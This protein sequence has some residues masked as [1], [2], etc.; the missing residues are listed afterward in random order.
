[1]KEITNPLRQDFFPKDQWGPEYIVKA[2]DP[3]TRMEGILVID[4]T[5]LG[6]GKGG[7]RMTPDITEEEIFRLARAMTM[8]N[9]LA[10][11]SFG[12]AKS[13]I[14]YN[15]EGADDKKKLVQ[16]FAKAIKMFS[17]EKY[18]AG[19]DVNTGS[20]EMKWFAQAEGSWKSA[21]GKPSRVCI[22]IPGERKKRCGIPHELGSTGYGV[23]QAVITTL[24]M[25]EI[26]IKSASVAIDGFGNVGSFV[27]KYLKNEGAH[28]VAVSDIRGTVYDKKGLDGEELMKTKK[29]GMPVIFYS[30]GVKLKRNAIFRL[31]VD[32]LIPA[33]V[34]DVINERNKNSVKA[35]VI[36]EAANIPMREKIEEE[37]FNRGIFVAPDIVVNAGGVISS[38]AEYSGLDPE[39]M[40]G[41]VKRKITGNVKKIIKESLRRNCNPR[42]VALEM[43]VERLVKK[44]KKAW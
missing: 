26:D 5:I 33:S 1:M 41:L 44:R 17:P 14:R 31:P 12:G 23:V 36:I 18:I 37:L 2:Y 40:F 21:T 15:P 9:A 25:L 8:K 7:I 43:A 6:P 42:E 30:G 27:F 10:G 20:R 39:K 35:K 38:Y 3:Q 29:L 34:T 4:N 32:V 24:R 22:R 13:G 11:I 19:P 16:S 28:I